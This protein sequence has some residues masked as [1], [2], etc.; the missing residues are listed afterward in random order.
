MLAQAFGGLVPVGCGVALY[1]MLSWWLRVPEAFSL[2]EIV[3]RRLRPG[4]QR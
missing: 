2:L 3:R 1:G 4:P